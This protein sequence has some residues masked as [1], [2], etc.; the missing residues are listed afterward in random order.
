MPTVV[1]LALLAGALGL[2]F[3]GRRRRGTG[4]PL[5]GPL[6]LLLLGAAVGLAVAVEVPRALRSSLWL[7]AGVAVVYLT[8]CGA[9]TVLR[10]Q[11][12][13]GLVVL[14]GVGVAVASPFLVKWEG[15]GPG[16]YFLWPELYR[17]FPLLTETPLRANSV[18]GALAVLLAFTVGVLVAPGISPEPRSTVGFRSV[19]HGF[20]SWLQHRRFPNQRPETGKQKPVA[21]ASGES[22]GDLGA[23]SSVMLNRSES[24]GDPGASSSVMLSRS[25]ASPRSEPAPSRRCFAAAQ[26]DN[27]RAQHDNR[28]DR[29]SGM[30]LA[31][32]PT[33][34]RFLL[35]GA[36][37]AMAFGLLLTQARNAMVSLLVGLTVVGLLRLPWL[38]VAALWA[39]LIAV[40]GLL[41]R[42]SPMAPWTAY[43]TNRWPLWERVAD[44]LLLYPLTGVG[45]DHLPLAIPFARPYFLGGGGDAFT[46]YQDRI[47]ID[48]AHNGLLQ[49]W[50]DLGLMGV[51]GLIWLVAAVATSVWRAGGWPSSPVTLPRGGRG[52]TFGARMGAKWREG[53]ERESA[54]QVDDKPSVR[55]FSRRFAAFV[56][57]TSPLPPALQGPAL[58]AAGGLAAFLIQ[59]YGESMLWND[60]AGFVLWPLLGLWLAVLRWHRPN[61]PAPFPRREGGVLPE[62]GTSLSPPLPA[63]GR[64]R[65]WGL[66]PP[67]PAAGRGR[68]WGLP[69]PLPAA[70][71]GRGWGHAHGLRAL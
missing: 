7:A 27:R 66:P 25:E 35:L 47:L 23:S 52:E 26:H 18:G 37:L 69:P 30:D 57:Q 68:G 40:A 20:W 32:T 1:A 62:S 56:I 48:H 21:G 42:A 65:G 41:F 53:R 2:L 31:N 71:R 6:G 70:G 17:S 64:G 12:M 49:T 14:T 44:L 36:G 59:Q 28:R 63:A 13:T 43:L 39:A 8:A 24:V 50:A 22:A 45:L 61:P 54:E 51:I 15:V 67:L 46:F 5:A 10:M 19:V 16:K 3:V 55:A 34:V 4:L 33:A 11:L 58:G 29:R 38:V 9:R 60:W